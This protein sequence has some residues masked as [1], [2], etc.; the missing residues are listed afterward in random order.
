[1]T[2]VI[3]LPTLLAKL[4]GS[5]LNLKTDPPRSQLHNIQI[6][7]SRFN[8]KKM[9][10]TLLGKSYDKQAVAGTLWQAIDAKA[11]LKFFT[12]AFDTLTIDQYNCP[13]RLRLVQDI[14]WGSFAACCRASKL[15]LDTIQDW[16]KLWIEGI[17][18]PSM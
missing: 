16:V 5:D 3:V 13:H 7:N 11:D 14:L 10:L 18:L 4:I 12:E 2:S 15:L 8:T 1:M 17:I 6:D 9:A